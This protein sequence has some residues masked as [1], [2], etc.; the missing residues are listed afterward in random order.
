MTLTLKL[1][2]VCAL[3]KVRV[4]AKY[5][6]AECSSLRVIMLTNFFVLSR[7]GKNCKY[8]PVTLNLDL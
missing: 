1:N 8:G 7:N 6:Q 4:R 3:V 2:R 5:P